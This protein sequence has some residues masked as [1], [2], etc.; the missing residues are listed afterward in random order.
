MPKLSDHEQRRRQI[1]EALLLIAATRGLHVASMR[2]VAAEAGVSVSTVQYYFHSKE[3]LLF[4]GL[5]Y[6][7]ESMAARAVTAGRSAGDPA[8]SDGGSTRSAGDPARSAL[9]GWLTQLIPASDEQRAS[10]TVFAAYH[11]LALT[12]RALAEQPYARHSTALERAVADHLSAARQ[13]GA[14]AAERDPATEAAN[15][16]AVVTGLADGVMGGLRTADAAR[17]LLR[18]HLDQVFRPLVR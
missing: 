13:A 18:Y 10:Y 14:M 11:A 3:Q 4:A 12:D 2:T 1:L 7:A 5:Q 17:D 6:A 9:E 8:H 15:L 16:I